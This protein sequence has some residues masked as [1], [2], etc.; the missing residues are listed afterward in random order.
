MCLTSHQGGD[1]PGDGRE[2]RYHSTLRNVHDPS[3]ASGQHVYSPRECPKQWRICVTPK[4]GISTNTYLP[5]YQAIRFGQ[6]T[7]GRWHQQRVHSF[8]GGES[9]GRVQPK[10]RPTGP[11]TLS[12]A[13]AGPNTNGS[14]FITVLPTP[15]LDNKHTVL[16]GSSRNGGG[17]E[18][19]QRL[20]F[21][22]RRT[23]PTTTYR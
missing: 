23:N 20:R 11:Y 17:A 19:I 3:R 22:P 9:R 18:H 16:V 8:W 1:H 10:L 5:S 15:W 14:Q 4:T 21:I 13:N 12:L 7:H 2:R 6:E